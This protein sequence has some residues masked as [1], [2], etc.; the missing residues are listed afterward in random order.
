MGRDT[1]ELDIEKLN[2]LLSRAYWL[3]RENENREERGIPLL[4]PLQEMKNWLDDIKK[5]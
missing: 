4:D 3:G 1:L 5:T 2:Y